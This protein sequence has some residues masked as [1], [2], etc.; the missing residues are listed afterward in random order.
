MKET[1]IAKDAKQKICMVV[2]G[3]NNCVADK[4]LAYWEIT[5]EYREI[6][7]A[8]EGEKTECG[9][10]DGKGSWTET[11]RITNPTLTPLKA[12]FSKKI[13]MEQEI[14]CGTCDG[15]GYRIFAIALPDSEQPGRCTANDKR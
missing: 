2:P 14:E 12:F 5:K 9:Y 6:K 10:C 15:K 8:D 3:M 13:E 1:M 11:V 7:Y 4:C